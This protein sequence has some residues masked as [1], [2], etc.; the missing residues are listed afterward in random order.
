[1]LRKPKGKYLPEFSDNIR[2]TLQNLKQKLDEE[3][4][5]KKDLA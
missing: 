3:S 4:V 2:R 5:I 1:M